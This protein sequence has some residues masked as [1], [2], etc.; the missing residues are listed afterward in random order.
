MDQQPTNGSERHG[1]EA[2]VRL[3]AIVK[4]LAL[5]LHPNRAESVT[6]DSSLDRDL[7]FDSLGRVEL[8]VRIERAFDITLPETVFATSE[9][10]RDLLRA[11]L[12]AGGQSVHTPAAEV[13]EMVLGRTEGLPHEA[14][15]LVD[16][17]DWHAEAHPDRPHIRFYQ[18]DGRGD[19][20]T[21]GALHEGA[22]RMAAGLQRMGLRPGETVAIMLPTGADYFHCFFGILL[23]GGI[24]VAMYPSGRISQI[25][26]HLRRHAAI[27]ANALAC[28]LITVP[29]AARFGRLLKA[30]VETLRDVVTPE[31]LSTTEESLQ[32]PAVGAADI[33]FLQ[34]TSGSTGDP[35]GVVLTHDN[36]LANIRAMGA[37]MEVKS[38]DVFVSW[39]PLYHDM[40]L[41]AAWL[42]SLYFATH[43]VIMSPLAFL[44]RPERWLWAVHRHHGTLSSAPNFAYELCLRRIEDKEIEGLDLSSWRV[45]SNGAEAVSPETLERFCERF[46]P[47]GFRREAL[48]PTYGLAECSVGL[49]VPPLGREPLIDRVRRAPFM[50]SGEAIPATDSD[51]KALRH[52]ACGS[53]LSGHEIRIVDPADR[54]LPERREGR[55]QFKG[56]SATSGYFR[57][58]EN[59]RRLFHGDWL[60]SGDL[61]YIAGGE[62]YIT[63]RAKDLIIRAGR[64]IYPDEFEVA[65][66]NIEGIL[67]GNVAVFGSLDED[68]ATERLVVLAETRRTKPEAREEARR[69]INALAVDLIETPPD[70]IVLA[71]PGTVLKTSSGK[72]RRSACKEIY[73]RGLIGKPPMAVRWQLARLA[74]GALVPQFHR[75][76]RAVS[77]ALYAA[78]AWSLAGWVMPV[79]WLAAIFVPGMALRR[80]A[81]R[82]VLRTLASVLRIPISVRGLENLPPVGRPCVLVSNHAS[83]V[84]SF[85]LVGTLPIGFAFVAK[86]ELAD[87]FITRVPLRRIGTEFVERFEKTKGA[88]DAQRIARVVEKGS[89]LLFFAEGTLSRM[90]GL[91]P[92]HMGAF[93]VAAETRVPVIPITIRGTRSILRGLSWFPRRS[94]VSVVVEEP[95]DTKAV[96][97]QSK[98]D[99][100]AVAVALRNKTRERILKHCGEPD[101]AHETVE[102]E[103]PESPPGGT[104]DAAPR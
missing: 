72:I 28:A 51:D 58:P 53:P 4:E 23:A 103:R 71:S 16:V 49:A 11:V 8:L 44:S 77:E 70:E 20:I 102:P 69:R 94:A 13:A 10:P 82:A 30:Q 50:R 65:I 76:R 47:Y 95:I 42:G 54:E 99:A 79:L 91:L 73:E 90:P 55:L 87:R 40:G 39:L 48:M 86:A 93:T 15:T 27:L 14:R 9:T 104:G 60:D 63:G 89:P 29:E 56:P 33:A 31:D 43:L 100:W 92:F 74:L 24:P 61:A 18:D 25:E 64:N 32:L 45:A 98:G 83:Y 85:V 17:L 96:W 101:L 5:E 1:A 12:G 2:V 22:R 97:D 52:V 38:N 80:T 68:S 35:K 26:E 78:Y 88:E 67:K 81:A 3:L 6:L 46:G 62:V 75:M 57:N 66:G 36:L 84:D 59:T 34:Y 7:G 21:Y 37:A 41:I 19:I